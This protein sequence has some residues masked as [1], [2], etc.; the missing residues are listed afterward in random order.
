MEIR[1]QL[2]EEEGST[3]GIVLEIDKGKEKQGGVMIKKKHM[4]GQMRRDTDQTSSID[5]T[6]FSTTLRSSEWPPTRKAG[7]S[8][9]PTGRALTDPSR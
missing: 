4:R 9:F 5:V 8:S 1:R 6:I 7:G 2:H 3:R